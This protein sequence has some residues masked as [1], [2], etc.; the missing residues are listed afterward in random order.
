MLY[1]SLDE[2]AQ[3]TKKPRSWLYKHAKEL[4][5]KIGRRW[6]FTAEWLDGYFQDQKSLVCQGDPQGTNLSARTGFR[7]KRR[8]LS[9]PSADQIQTKINQNPQYYAK[10][11][12]RPLAIIPPTQ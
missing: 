7:Q 11:L 6:S 9:R 10:R 2:A 4:G 8:G 12:S 3:Y 5:V 1:L